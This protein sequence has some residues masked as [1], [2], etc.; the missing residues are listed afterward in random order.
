MLRWNQRATQVLMG[1]CLKKN[2]P[3][4][5]VFLC[6]F[7][8]FIFVNTA[9]Y[10]YINSATNRYIDKIQVLSLQTHREDSEWYSLHYLWAHCFGFYGCNFIASPHSRAC[11]SAAAGGCLHLWACSIMCV[12]RVPGWPSLKGVTLSRANPIC[13]RPQKKTEDRFDKSLAHIR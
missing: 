2:K 12:A 10:L 4:E 6:Y 8:G 3:I 7:K 11:H 9:L 13:S 5:S 1:S